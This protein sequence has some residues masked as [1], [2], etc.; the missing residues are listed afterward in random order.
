MQLTY[1]RYSNFATQLCTLCKMI[2]VV[3]PASFTQNKP[4]LTHIN[5]HAGNSQKHAPTSRIK[6]IKEWDTIT[7]IYHI[8]TI[9]KQTWEGVKQKGAPVSLSRVDCPMFSQL[10][11]SI[12]PQS[13]R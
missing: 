11:E 8:N 3:K 10:V 9:K 12:M 13:Q 6:R 2:Y 5:R 4:N 7:E 1:D